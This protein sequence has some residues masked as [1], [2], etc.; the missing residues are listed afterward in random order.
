M[1]GKEVNAMGVFAKGRFS[2]WLIV[3]L[4]IGADQKKVAAKGHIW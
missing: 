3:G 1:K 2:E 4:G